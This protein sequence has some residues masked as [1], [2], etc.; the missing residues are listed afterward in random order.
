[1]NKNFDVVVVGAGFTGLSA[2]HALSRNGLKV[3]VVESDA[4][5]GGLAGTFQFSDGVRLEKFYHHWFNNDLYVPMLAK[6][7]GLEKEII[8]MPTKTG[9][10]FNSRMWRLSNP[11]DLL[12]FKPLPFLDR[13]RLGLLV[14]KVRRIKN[15]QSIEN[16][17][18]RE[19]LE[20]LC[21]KNVFKIVWEPLINAKFSIY[22]EQVNAVWM[23]KKLNLRGST[24]NEKG[25]EELAYF[26][27]G[28]GK[29]AEAITLEI[30]KKGGCVITNATVS[31]LNIKANKVE[32]LNTS[33]SVIRGSH[34]LFTPAFPIIA[35]IFSDV[36][37]S[38]W[39]SKLRRVRYL[40]NMC[41]VLRLKKSLSE[42]YWLN[43]NDPG[44]PFVG[45]IEHTN[46]DTPENYKGSHIVYLSRYLP[47]E[48]PKWHFSDEDYLKFS[49]EHLQRMFPD[50][51]ES[52]LIDYK[53]WRSEFAQP[54]TE[55]H[56]SQYIPGIE[57][58]FKNACIASMAQ[59]YPEDRGTNYAIRD[60][61]LIADHIIKSMTD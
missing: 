50:L 6:E 25:G 32:S 18:I 38:E 58:P 19:W 39:L 17:S 45:V 34:F 13:I 61:K 23:W 56:Y 30:Q 36:A 57:T 3:C 42:T 48:D 41:L 49:F 55:R 1:M 4:A 11:L 59:I 27:G 9:M 60:G 26:K 29:L 24:R 43:V 28:F 54:V 52:W 37:D 7:L 21:G 10:Y 2:A 47:A 53:V 44:F 22:A 5:V 33:R 12:G 15:W 51:D 46:F 20:S 40:G 14:L 31:G 16:L 8:T 35:N